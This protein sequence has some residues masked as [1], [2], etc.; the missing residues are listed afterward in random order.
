MSRLPA[1]T[2]EGKRIAAVQ[3]I[4][5]EGEIERRSRTSMLRFHKALRTLGLNPTEIGYV[6]R[7]NDYW[8]GYDN[9]FQCFQEKP[10][11]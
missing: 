7:R 6:M 11:K 9:P 10:K 5:K 3:L 1:D 4:I 8:D 2:G